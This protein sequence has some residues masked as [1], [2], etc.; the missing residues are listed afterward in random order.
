MKRNPS[1]NS[2]VSDR[3]FISNHDLEIITSLSRETCGDDYVE[4][5]KGVVEQIRYAELVSNL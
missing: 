5:A 2:G 4:V 3:V 1:A